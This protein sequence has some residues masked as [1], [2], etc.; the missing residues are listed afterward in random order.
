[1]GTDH[2]LHD[3]MINGI[4]S[5]NISREGFA[6]NVFFRH[7]RMEVRQGFGQLAE[8]DVGIGHN[9]EDA[10]VA[11]QKA[12]EWGYKKHL[13]SYLFN[14]DFGHVQIV[15]AFAARVNT[16]NELLN[17]ISAN[18]CIISIYDVTTG[19]RWEEP[20]HRHTGENNR[21]RI[22]MPRWRGTHQTAIDRDFQ[23]WIHVDGSDEF[24]FIEYRGILFFGSTETGM[25]AYFPTIFN[26]NRNKQID[27]VN[28][29]DWHPLYAE[30]SIIIRATPSEGVFAEGVTYFRRAEFPNP[31][32]LTVANNRLVYAAGRTI[33]FSEPG[34]PTNIRADNFIQLS[35]VGGPITALAAQF[36][37]IHIY[38]DKEVWTYHPNEGS[39]IVS[40]G[41]LN[42]LSRSIGCSG[43]N[44]ITYRRNK[45]I[46]SDSNGVYAT[47]GNYVVE[48]LSLA[49]DDLFGERGLS[50][51]TT[52]YFTQ[53]GHAFT[54]L[55]DQPKTFYRYDKDRVQLTYWHDKDLTFLSL[56][57]EN[58]TL[59]LCDNDEWAIWIYESMVTVE[60]DGSPRV[61][62]IRNIREPWLLPHN[63]ELYLVGGPA[64]IGQ[65]L[66]DN[67]IR[68]GGLSHEGS[69]TSFSYYICQ[70]SRGGALDRNT[71]L[72]DNRKIAGKYDRVKSQVVDEGVI[73]IDEP[74]Y[75]DAFDELPTDI[76][77]SSNL[78]VVV[79]LLPIV[80]VPRAP[81]RPLGAVTSIKIKIRFDDTHWTTILS[82]GST[83]IAFVLPPE[84]LNSNL[85]YTP[86]SPIPGVSEVR[87][88][89]FSTGAPH[90]SGDEIRIYWDSATAGLDMNLVSNQRNRLIYIP[91]VSLGG[92][93]VDDIDGMGLNITLASIDA[94]HELV[95]TIWSGWVLSNA[96]KHWLN[97][98]TVQ[99]VDWAYKT[100]NIVA[101]DGSLIT[102]H[103]LDMRVESHGH[104]D[105]VADLEQGWREG[106]VNVITDNDGVM[107]YAQLVD[108]RVDTKSGTLGSVKQDHINLVTVKE[109][110]TDRLNVGT[111]DKPLFGVI[112]VKWSDEANPAL[113]EYLIGDP[114]IEDLSTT[115]RVKGRRV[116]FLIYG[117]M[118]NRANR[119]IFQSIEGR[120]DM[121]PAGPHIRHSS[122]GGGSL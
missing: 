115:S 119:L 110:Y 66:T 35:D 67:T 21:D 91:M 69:T 49:I 109:S 60:V 36:G 98:S 51:P 1:M 68:T 33:Y 107:S 41:R 2:K 34:Q 90:L 106:M 4:V 104:G 57:A 58:C 97:Q 20:L 111:V 93:P 39:D 48:N 87:L 96:S 108:L 74:I 15:S 78:G 70:Y 44:A 26:G 112:N 94:L 19:D 52:H 32:A 95:P 5:N 75:L 84:R 82:G 102:A 42:P 24:Y 92:A 81:D 121:Q 7:G 99:S 47:T 76:L 117:H 71:F 31:T 63:K 118:R 88:Y 54:A 10:T 103:G 77:V 45:V 18:L 38:T 55:D 13:G 56:P 3:V 25:L 50:D 28:E 114:L 62:A 46:W 101:G 89:K 43:K 122:S 64:G 65:A 53:N 22:P 79:A 86:G 40:L 16:G 11:T 23:D 17:G 73:Y 72:E 113:V 100:A 30:T 80:I 105:S 85:G 83:E 116:S 14:T 8:Y 6:K 120:F 9:F 27:K 59:V 61:R 29:Q 12:F 37:N